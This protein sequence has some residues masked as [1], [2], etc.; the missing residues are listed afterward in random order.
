MFYKLILIIINIIKLVYS[1]IIFTSF[2]IFRKFNIIEKFLTT[3]N[4]YG[5]IEDLHK[6]YNFKKNNTQ[7]LAVFNHV[8][9]LDGLLLLNQFKEPISF[10][11]SENILV[12]L[13]KKFIENS[14]GIIINKNE[15]TT[16]KITNISINRQKNDPILFIAPSGTDGMDQKEELK[17]SEFRTGAFVS[18][19]P[20]LPVIIKYS[21][22][23]R[24]SNDRNQTMLNI[25]TNTDYLNY[26]IKVLDPIY[27][28]K[29]DNI[30]SFKDRVYETMNIEKNKL[31]VDNIQKKQDNIFLFILINIFLLL[32]YLL[33]TNTIHYLPLISIIIICCIVLFFK[34]TH[35]IY[36]YLYSNIIY[37]Y[38]IIILIYSLINSNYMLF[39]QVLI[40]TILYK[41]CQK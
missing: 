11:V 25:I 16:Q 8:S 36:D 19:K 32:S 28:Q 41:L 38:T 21:P 26:K 6:Y 23:Y 37:F 14:N 34:N 5:N 3:F 33:Y 7:G 22:Y 29:Y 40:C 12:S 30:Q 10:L 4:I 39:I 2:L 31:K 17:L 9:I 1:I 15:N 18:L 24:D 27:P 20:I 13:C 35:Y